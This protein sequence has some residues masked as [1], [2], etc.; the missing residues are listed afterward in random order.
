MQLQT[1]QN[2]IFEIRGQKVMFDFDLAFVYLCQYAYKE[3]EDCLKE[4]E[5][6]FS[7]ITQAINYL[8]GKDQQETKQK[9]IGFK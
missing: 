4:L 2:K 6:N 5:G 7:D 9:K 3:L 8:L 1:I